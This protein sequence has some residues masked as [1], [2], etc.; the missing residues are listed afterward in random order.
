MTQS[1]IYTYGAKSPLSLKG[2]F[3]TTVES[4]DKI[5][6]AQIFVADGN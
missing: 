2:S 5:T 6:D 4:K 3:H 1:N